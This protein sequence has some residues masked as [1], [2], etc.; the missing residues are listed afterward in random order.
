MRDIT[1]IPKDGH[2]PFNSMLYILVPFF[3]TKHSSRNLKR[4]IF[5]SVLL[6]QIALSLEKSWKIRVIWMPLN[7]IYTVVSVNHWWWTAP[8]K[9]LS[10]LNVILRFA[11]KESKREIDK[12]NKE[13]R[14][15]IFKKFMIDMKNGLVD[16]KMSRFLSLIPE[17]MTLRILNNLDNL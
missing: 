3:G 2:L 8:L 6:W 11:M 15:N 17:Y 12:A 16:K 13:F 4:D 10:I 14:Y 7:S 9:L 5:P 1:Q